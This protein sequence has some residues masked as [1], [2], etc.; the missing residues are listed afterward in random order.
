[1]Q[2][3]AFDQRNELI[4]LATPRG[5]IIFDCT[6]K[7]VLYEALF[8]AGGANCIA[9]L[10]DSNV[11]AASGDDSRNG[12]LK[13]TVILWECQESK[14][15]RLLDVSDPV[16][17]LYFRNDVLVVVFGSNIN[18][19]DCCDFSL[20]YTTTNPIPH[21]FC[22]SLTQSGNYNLVAFPSSKGDELN[23]SD[24]HDPEQ[25][26]GS[27]PIPFSRINYFAFDSK[28]EL[29]AIVCDEGKTIQLW[30]VMELK[31]IAKFKRGFRSAEVSGLAF[32]HLSNYFIMTT[33]RGTMHV[34][35]IPSKK[36]LKESSKANRSSFSFEMQK[37]TEFH[38]QFDNA[39]YII[40][41]IT[42]DGCFQQLRLDIDKK[43]IVPLSNSIQIEM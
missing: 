37:G 30:S 7:N 6:I 13:S 5:F 41:G 9:L 15:I 39:G 26:L 16:E 25:I 2:H 38:Y 29:L 1:M 32:D 22:V 23:I 40:S 8:P 27:I 14:V 12:F 24:Y 10:S 35:E 20:T 28:C 33:K 3:T 19:Y 43:V 4:G 11:V 42:D 21:R 31:L 34:F 36:D 18:F 17:Y